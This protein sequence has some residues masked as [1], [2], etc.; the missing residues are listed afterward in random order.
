MGQSPAIGLLLTEL[1]LGNSRRKTG[2]RV[3]DSYLS[4]RLA[5]PVECASACWQ[6][7]P[8]MELR[9][10]AGLAV[11]FSNVFRNGTRKGRET[12]KVVS[13]TAEDETGEFGEDGR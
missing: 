6:L 1:R 7:R 2:S 5:W 12:L 11:R 8:R 9:R 13:Y 3:K 10:R 4:P